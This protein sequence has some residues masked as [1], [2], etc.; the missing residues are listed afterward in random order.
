MARTASGLRM[1]G[2]WMMWAFWAAG[3]SLL[4]VELKSGMEY[5]EA[6]LEQN[7]A[8]LLGCLPA[9][10]MITLNFAEH[11]VWHWSAVQV[12]LQSVPMVATGL[13]LVFASVLLNRQGRNVQ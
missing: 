12:A 2:S 5:L 6:G 9:M 10:G 11:S 1:S 3:V 7:M 13:L 8:G 4:L